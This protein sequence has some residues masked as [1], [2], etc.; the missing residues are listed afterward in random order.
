MNIL[1]DSDVPSSGGVASSAALELSLS[2]GILA[3]LGI[4][5]NPVKKAH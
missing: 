3:L 4:E 2:T 1:I 5:V